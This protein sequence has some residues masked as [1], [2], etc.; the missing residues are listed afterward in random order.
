M[1]AFVIAAGEYAQTPTSATKHTRRALRAGPLALMQSPG[2]SNASD[3][4]SSTPK[5][6]TRALEANGRV[7]DYQ[8]HGKGQAAVS[9]TAE[10]SRTQT[11]VLGLL[12]NLCGEELP[13]LV[14]C[15][16]AYPSRRKGWVAH[17]PFTRS[18]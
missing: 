6:A 15:P 16:A 2:A 14:I 1:S 3:A 11:R 7:F 12:L 13:K 8:P 9:R 18:Q 5:A 10:L 17:I 4:R